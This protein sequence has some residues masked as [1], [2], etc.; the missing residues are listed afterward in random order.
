MAYRSGCDIVP[1]CI[2]TKGFKYG[3]FRRKEIIFGKV[4]PYSELGFVNGGNEE[5]KRATDKIF[6]EIISLGGYDKLPEA[7]EENK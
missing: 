5:Y 3:F 7:S 1:V 6:G 4:I 2:K